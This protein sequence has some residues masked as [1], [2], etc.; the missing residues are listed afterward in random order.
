[1]TVLQALAAVENYNESALLEEIRIVRGSLDRPYI[2][3]ADLARTFTYGWR[4]ETT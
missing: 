4:E 1:M 3:T 2:V